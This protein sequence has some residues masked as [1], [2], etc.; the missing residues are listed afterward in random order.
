MKV[1]ETLKLIDNIATTLQGKYTFSDIDIYLA[2]FNVNPPEKDMGYNSKRVY[3]KDRLKGVGEKELKKIAADLD[4]IVGDIVSDSPKNWVGTTAVKAFISH[5]V[6]KKEIAVRLRDALKSSNIDAFVAH[7]DIRPSEEWQIE[8][9]KALNVMD[10]FISIHTKGFHES[11]WCQQEVGYAVCRGV[12]IIAI[13]FDENPE[14]FIA[15]IQALNRGKKKAESVA[16]DIIEI[17]KSDKKTKDIYEEKI[18]PMMIDFDG[19]PF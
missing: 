4:L 13:K 12:K 10:F 6:K 1:S 15:R 16:K 19:I 11:I 5:V 3:V 9:Q 2:E 14:G 7:E 18:E 8:I 17:L